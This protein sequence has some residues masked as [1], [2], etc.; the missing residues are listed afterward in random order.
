L[1]ALD[2][3]VDKAVIADLDRLAAVL[4]QQKPEWEPGEREAYCML[5]LGFYE[6]D[7]L[8][9]VDPLHRSLGQF[10]QDE[11]ASPLGLDFYIRLPADIPNSRLASIENA[12]GMP[13]AGGSFA[14][15]NPEVGAGYACVMNRMRP[16]K[17]A[18]PREWAVRSAFHQASGRRA[19]TKAFGY[20]EV[21]T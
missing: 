7:L 5:S 20:T 4:A 21:Q 9:P 3:P 19:R 13:G 11:I 14:Y 2:A 16:P 10:F 6:G 12:F 17:K 18:D 1:F 15:A 8:R